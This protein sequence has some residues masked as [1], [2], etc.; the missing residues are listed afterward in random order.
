MK[1]DNFI[2]IILSS[3]VLTSCVNGQW[4]GFSGIKNFGRYQGQV[5]KDNINGYNNLGQVAEGTLLGNS[6]MEKVLGSINREDLAYY[7][8]A[9]QNTLENL[10]TGEDSFWI[11]PKTGISGIVT[12]VKTFEVSGIYCRKYRQTIALK[13]KDISSSETAC[14]EADGVW[15]IRNNLK[16]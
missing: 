2:V 12:A 6:L 5:N 9:S 13:N 4:V 15:K 3:L 11:N 1:L 8:Q 16:N 14:R 7:H 10:P